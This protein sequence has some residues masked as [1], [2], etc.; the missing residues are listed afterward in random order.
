MH[1]FISTYKFL[2]QKYYKYRENIFGEEKLI[3]DI[4]F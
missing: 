3:S 1:W 4:A 2:I